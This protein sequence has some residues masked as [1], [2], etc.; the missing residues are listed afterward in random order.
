MVRALA[1]LERDDMFSPAGQRLLD[2]KPFSGAYAIRVESLRDLFE[3]V[4]REIAAVAGHLARRLKGHQGYQ[5]IEALNG[6][7][8]I[9]AAIFVS[10]IG[11]VTRFASARHL[12]SWA[13]LTPT[14]RESDQNV[15]RGHITKQGNT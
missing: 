7:G 4:D 15:R 3:I 2:K 8:P 11:D 6:V 13:G 14:H 10:E 9:L 1:G 12:C 5:A